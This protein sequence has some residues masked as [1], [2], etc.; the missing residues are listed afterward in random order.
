M[1]KRR[2]CAH[3]KVDSGAFFIEAGAEEA[4]GAERLLL[5]MTEQGLV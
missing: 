5:A 4:I 3:W 1:W 2:R